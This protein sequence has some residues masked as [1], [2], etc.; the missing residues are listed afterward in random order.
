MPALEYSPYLTYRRLHQKSVEYRP[1]VK[2]VTSFG[3]PESPAIAQLKAL[4]VRPNNADYAQSEQ[5][6]F[7][8]AFLIT[9]A[10]SQHSH[11]SR[12]GFYR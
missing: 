9:K 11:L 3:D 7:Y 2:Q 8:Y 6:H 10:L 1:F 4:V 5:T 12:F